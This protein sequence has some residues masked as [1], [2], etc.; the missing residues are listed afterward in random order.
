MVWLSIVQGWAILLVIIGHVNGFTYSGADPREV[1]P[2]SGFIHAL[3][4]SFHMPLFM[5]ASG[6]LLYYSRLAKGWKTAPLYIDKLRRLALPYLFFTTVAFFIKGML[7]AYTKRGTDFTPGGFINAVF[8]PDNGPLREM[9]FIGTLMWLMLLYPFYKVMLRSK[10]AEIALLAI[11]LIPFLLNVRVSFTGWFNLKGVF[12]FAFYFVAG[13]LFFK[14]S[15]YRFFERRWIWSVVLTAAFALCVSLGL[16]SGIVVA[17][18]GILMSVAW[19]V[20]LAG[21]VPGLFSGFRDHSFQ[22]FLIGIFPQMLV[23]LFVWKRMHSPA[24]QLPY[25]LL[26]CAAAIACAVIVARYASRIKWPWLR[27]CF[28][29]R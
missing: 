14:Y 16:T 5:F 13:I 2:L 10:W 26:S 18:L 23:E 17:S 27:W 1:Y 11:T 9:W 28:G 24:L 3:C 4:Y 12:Y 19:G 15:L 7:S 25:Y 6:G 20:F 22:I 21:R 8:D 29:L